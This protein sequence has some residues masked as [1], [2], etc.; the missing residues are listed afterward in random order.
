VE[1][2]KQ[3]A[4]WRALA[5]FVVWV[6]V[7]AGAY[8]YFLVKPQQWFDVSMQQPPVLAEPR[9]QQL[10]RD[11]LQRHFPQLQPNTAW[12]VRMKQADCGCERFVELYHQSFSAQVDPAAMQVVEVDLSGDGYTHDELRLLQT[13][14]PATPSVV[15]FNSAAEVAYFGPYHQEGICNAENSYL[16]PVLQALQQGRNLSVLNTLVYGCFCNIHLAH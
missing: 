14:I 12:F 6:L 8:W 11:L 16:E 9:Q 10:L 4:L 1:S 13:L 7:L 15:V 2:A 5:F 3:Q